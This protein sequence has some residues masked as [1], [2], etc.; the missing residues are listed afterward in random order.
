MVV[1]VTTLSAQVHEGGVSAER[2]HHE[3]GAQPP[4][5]QPRG[6]GPVRVRRQQRDEQGRRQGRGG[7]LP[8]HGPR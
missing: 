6:R 1:T 8:Q 4:Q 5:L 7:R 2:V 3:D